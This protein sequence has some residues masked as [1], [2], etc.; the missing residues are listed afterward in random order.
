MVCTIFKIRYCTIRKEC[1]T[2]WIYL[3]FKR[4]HDFVNWN[5]ITREMIKSP[6]QVVL[7]TMDQTF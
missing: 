7:V 5:C 2:Y 6:T 1:D 3:I 4:H